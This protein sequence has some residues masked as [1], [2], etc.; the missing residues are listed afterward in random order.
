MHVTCNIEI[1]FNVRIYKIYMKFNEIDRLPK[2]RKIKLI[3]YDNE[4]AIDSELLY[5]RY[6]V[7][8]K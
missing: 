1:A 4:R 2:L 7:H 8:S 3:E 6:D 5:L